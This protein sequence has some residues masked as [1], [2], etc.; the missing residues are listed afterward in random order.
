MKNKKAFSDISYIFL[1]FF[2]ISLISVW[3]FAGN[4]LFY[5]NNIDIRNLEAIT[6]SDKLTRTI[7]NKI[8]L[9]HDLTEDFN[10]Y[11]EANLNY[12]IINN[13]DYYFR[14]EFLENNNPIKTIEEGTR[15]FK[16]ECELKSDKFPQCH[17]N[18]I[19]IE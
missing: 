13:G 2:T 3:V 7:I 12:Q 4:N 17:K 14:I 9:N 18:T 6:L 5:H 1:F 10:I 8:N 16:V 15:S 11:E 19:F